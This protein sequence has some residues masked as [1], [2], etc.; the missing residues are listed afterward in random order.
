MLIGCL[1]KFPRSNVSLILTG[2]TDTPDK[3]LRAKLQIDVRDQD[4]LIFTQGYCLI[5]TRPV[6]TIAAFNK[7]NIRKLRPVQLFQRGH[8]RILRAIVHE[9]YSQLIERI[10]LGTETRKK[11]IDPFFTVVGH[12]TDIN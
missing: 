2:K 4:E 1:P 5:V 9:Y 3:A 6:T 10:V 12:Y 11:S 8:R 7:V